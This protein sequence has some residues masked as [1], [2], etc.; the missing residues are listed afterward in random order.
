M[1]KPK[2][3]IHEKL[4][5]FNLLDTEKKRRFSWNFGNEL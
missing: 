3:E 5:N 4:E 1:I 2:S